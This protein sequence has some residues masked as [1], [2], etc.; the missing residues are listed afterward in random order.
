MKKKCHKH[1][2]A[3]EYCAGYAHGLH[4]FYTRENIPIIETQDLK[5][6]MCTIISEYCREMAVEFICPANEFYEL[7]VAHIDGSLDDKHFES[8]SIHYYNLTI[9]GWLKWAEVLV[10]VWL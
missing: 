9:D 5:H 3:L 10:S 4:Y 8:N 1:D 2:R 6:I 7:A